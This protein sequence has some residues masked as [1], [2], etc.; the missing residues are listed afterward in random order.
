MLVSNFPNC[1]IR[2]ILNQGEKVHNVRPRES[3]H[4]QVL[5][6]YY[7]IFT[8]LSDDFQLAKTILKSESL[9]VT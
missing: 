5:L 2:L 8:L 3:P 7:Y 6:G 9:K 1:N 4:A